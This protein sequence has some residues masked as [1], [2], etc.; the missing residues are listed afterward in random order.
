[1]ACVVADE[2]LLANFRGG[3]SGI[4]VNVLL[5]D[6]MMERSNDRAV[7]LDSIWDGDGGDGNGGGIRLTLWVR[8]KFPLISAPFSEADPFPFHLAHHHHIRSGRE[9]HSSR[10]Q[11]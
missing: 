6:M 2:S 3:K 8:V 11:R 9:C 4:S 5:V 1:M 7:G 10:R